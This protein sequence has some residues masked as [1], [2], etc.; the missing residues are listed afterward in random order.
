VALAIVRDELEITIPDERKFG[1]ELHRIF[2]PRQRRRDAG[3]ERGT[4]EEG[5]IIGI[6]LAR[7]AIDAGLS[8]KQLEAFGERL[9]HPNPSGKGGR[10][11]Y[12][13]PEYHSQSSGRA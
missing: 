4:V 1:D 3:D 13:F 8:Q 12:R 9:A 2:E 10:L 11:S 7:A 5:E 6:R